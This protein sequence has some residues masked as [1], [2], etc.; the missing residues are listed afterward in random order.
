MLSSSSPFACLVLVVF[1]LLASGPA[2]G[3]V[4][5]TFPISDFEN[6]IGG[7]VTN[8]AI[9]HS[10]QSEDTPLVSVARSGG[11]HHGQGCLEIAFHP[12]EGWA[13]AYM[14]V[15]RFG[16]AW[17]DAGV[18]ELAFWMRG[19][20]QEKEVTIHLQAWSDEH[21]PA[22]FGVPVS[23]RDTDWHEVVIPLS[24]FQAAN[25]RT[26]LRL[27]SVHAFQVD[28]SG[29][30]GP[31]RLWI[32][33]VRARNARGEGAA[34]AAG[35]HDERL[36]ELPA[37]K[38]LPRLGMW[39]LTPLTD[40]GLA[41]ARRLGLQ[42][43]SNSETRLQQ[44]LAFLEGIV[45]N[46]CPG[47][48]GTEVL[49]G[50]GFSDEDFDQDSEGRRMSEGMQ[51]AVFSEAVVERFCRHIGDRVRSRK[52]APQVCSFMLSS[53]ISM[54]GEV[55]YAASEGHD[56]AVFGRPAK[57]NYRAWLKGQYHDDL[58]AL[59]AAWGRP[60]ASWED[61]VPP[62]GPQGAEGIDTRTEWSDFIHWYNWWLEEVTRRGLQAARTETD[63]PLAV[64]IGG[65]KIG[66]S[67]GI[68]LGNVGPIARLLG[69][70]APAFLSDTD[71]Q[72]LF[73][74]RYTRTACSQYGVDLMIEHVGPP[75]LHRFHQYN[76]A[77]NALACGAD[78]AHLAQTG[79]LYD[80]EHWFGPTWGTLAPLVLGY[81]TGYVKSEVALFHS[82]MTSWY[83]PERSNGDCVRLY[84]ST[85][86]LWFPESGYP[87]WGRALGSPDV[88]DDVMVEDGGLAGRRLLVIPNTSV[89]V[90]SAKAVAA[91][92]RWVSAGGT[93]VGF[94]EGCLAW[95]VGAG[96]SLTATPGLAGLIPQAAMAASGDR[97]DV[98]VG[99]GRAV[100]YRQAA[101]DG[102]FQH[103]AMALLEA[104]MDRAG[105]PRRCRTD[106]GHDVNLMYAGK[107]KLSGRHLYV[108][109]FTRSVRSDP[110]EA[111]PEFWRNRDFKF[112][113]DDSLAGEAELVGLTNSFASCEG[114]KAEFDPESKIL[115]VRFR[116][117]GRLSVR[118]GP[119]R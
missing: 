94:G 3:Q 10:G 118:C 76:M 18:D 116:L 91:L 114:G 119:G 113:F 106:A 22:F 68:A 27:P 26:P 48:P 29:A 20:G 11:A 115:K 96:R 60:P 28:A 65:P 88:V 95:T 84:D 16:D 36:R 17:A 93:V 72:T 25:A 69:Q 81:R 56:Y 59:S 101:S 104:E 85:N 75:H 5:R 14:M 38:G 61:V 35:P 44:E 23:L 80:P 62:R 89:T 99:R 64:M 41:V 13:G 71:S 92:R 46:D 100:L 54:Y 98:R 103:Q 78:A 15:S 87:S 2:R 74:C 57:D 7:W 52:G 51:S 6:G 58:A 45:S 24:R 55:H 32:D 34:F 67:Q 108:A 107:D 63:K 77:L 97:I 83:R 37:A 112:G 40:E 111:E 49:D 1:A 110:P 105:V 53:P 66:L 47:R 86:T 109:D 82:Y 33:D 70:V 90:T 8:D 79:Q 9:K 50:L 31:A 30:I 43:G 102:P 39:G 73:S 12:G 117:P 4:G 21:V 42:F 19:D